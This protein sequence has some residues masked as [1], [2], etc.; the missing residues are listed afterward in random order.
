MY[1]T[2]HPHCKGGNKV[3]LAS[4]L[5]SDMHSRVYCC[6]SELGGANKRRTMAEA[7]SLSQVVLERVVAHTTPVIPGGH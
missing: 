1:S 4:P 2:L 3:A 5:Q 7:T 6:C